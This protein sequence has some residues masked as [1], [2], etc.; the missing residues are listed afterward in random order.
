MMP[1][2]LTCEYCGA[3]K[4]EIAFYIGAT[5][6]PDWCMIEGTGK[7]ACPACYKKASAEGQDRIYKHIKL[8]NYKFK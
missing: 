4:N 3:E 1:D 8:H 6:I 7:I 2:K 5:N